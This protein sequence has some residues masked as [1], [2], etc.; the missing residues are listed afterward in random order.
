MCKTLLLHPS[1]TVLWQV[2]FLN[3]LFSLAM[4]KSSY[5]WAFDGG[6]PWMNGGFP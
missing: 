5:Y 3:I 1:K 2:C 6:D 4:Q